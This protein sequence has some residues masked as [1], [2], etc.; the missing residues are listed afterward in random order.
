MIGSVRF[1]QLWSC[2]EIKIFQHN[3]NIKGSTD[4][5]NKCCLEY[6][7]TP[8][9]ANSKAVLCFNNNKKDIKICSIQIIMFKA[10]LYTSCMLNGILDLSRNFDSLMGKIHKSNG[11]G[12]NK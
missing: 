12:N 2:N 9:G 10:T 8:S 1:D 5:D 7:Y 11:K 6:E 4:S 3:E